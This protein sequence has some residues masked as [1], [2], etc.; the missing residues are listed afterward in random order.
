MT[1][2]VRSSTPSRPRAR[3]PPRSGDAEAD[4]HRVRRREHDVVLVIAPTPWWM[5]ST[6]TSGCW[7]S[8]GA[9][10]RRPRPPADVASSTRFAGP[11]RRLPASPR[12]A[13]RAT[14][15]AGRAGRAARGAGARRAAARARAPGARSRR[16]A[17]LARGRSLVEADDLDRVAGPCFLDALAVVVVERDLAPSA[18][19]DDGVPHA[20][21]SRRTSI[22][23]SRGRRPAATR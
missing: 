15:R 22:G 16:H 5:T 14:D 4:D 3:A 21:R 19:C 13:S 2:Y 12:R 11:G 17:L 10:T 20:Q 7:I 18:S 8:G 1:R 23:D 6:R 9:R